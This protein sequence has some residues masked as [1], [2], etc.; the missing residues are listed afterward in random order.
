MSRFIYVSLCVNICV[1]I[2]TY[3]YSHT[4]TVPS[5]AYLKLI[6]QR[7]NANWKL[8]QNKTTGEVHVARTIKMN[9]IVMLLAWGHPA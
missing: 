2:D 1:Y 6:S 7:S 3:V 4:E 5:G 8:H 9:E